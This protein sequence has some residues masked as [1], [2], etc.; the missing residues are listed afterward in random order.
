MKTCMRYLA[1]IFA[2]AMII[3]SLSSVSAAFPDVASDNKYGT[4]I[5]TMTNLGIIGGYEDGTFKPDGLVRRDEMAKIVFAAYTTY[6]DAGEGTITFPDV[7]KNSWAKGY[8]SWCAGKKIVGGYE[9]GT[10]RPEGNIT[11]DE[12]LKMVCAMLGYTNFDPEQWPIDV[13]VKGLNDL[14][15]GENLEGIA[16][17][18]AL[19]RAQIVQLVYNSLDKPTYQESD[20]EPVS[21]PLGAIGA[22]TLKPGS[23]LKDDVWGVEEIKAQIIGTEKYGFVDPEKE[24]RG[25]KTEEEDVILVRFEYE[26]GTIE[27]KKINLSDIGLDAYIGDSDGLIPL[28]INI[29]AKKNSDEYVSA[30]LIGTRK[31][32]ITG[33]YASTEGLSEAEKIYNG[34]DPYARFGVKVDGI[35]Y[36][37]EHFL[38]L[39]RLTYLEDIVI[40]TNPHVDGSGNIVNQFRLLYSWNTGHNRWNESTFSL[41][42]GFHKIMNA[43]DADSDGWY[44]YIIIEFKELFRVK[45]ITA[46]TVEFEYLHKNQNANWRPVPDYTHKATGEVF[47]GLD[48][49]FPIE[50]VEVVSALKEGMIVQGY[51]FGDTFTITADSTIYTGYIT[52]YDASGNKYTLDSGKTIG[53][54]YTSW[55]VWDSHSYAGTMFSNFN[56]SMQP[57]IGINGSTGDYNYAKFWTIEDKIIWAE[58]V[59][60][61][62]VSGSG[63]G[64]MKAILQ[65]VTEPTE[66]QVNEETK[67][68]EVFYPAYLLI[69]G[70][71]KLVNLNAKYAI[72]KFSAETVAQEGSPYR[73][74][75]VDD[76]GVNRIIY[77]NLLVTYEVDSDGYYTLHVSSESL[78]DPDTNEVIEMVIP[79]ADGNELSIDKKTGIVTIS[80][81]GRIVQSKIRIDEGSI[82]YYPY[83]KEL[84]GA[85]KYIDY[86]RGSEIPEEFDAAPVTS[87]IFLRFDDE[88]GLWVLSALLLGEKLEAAGEAGTD[89][90]KDARTHLYATLNTEAVV[91]GDKILASYAFKNLYT[92]EAI[93]GTKNSLEYSEA[94]KAEMNKI[95][96]WN[97]NGTDKNYV[98][99]TTT[100]CEA[101]KTNEV[102]TEMFD[103]MDIV[104]T[105]SFVDGIKIDDTVKVIAVT[106]K[107]TAE[108]KAIDVAELAEVYNTIKQYN[109]DHADDVGFTAVELKATI[110][111]YVNEFNKLS[112]AYILIDW[113][114]YDEELEALVF[115]GET[116]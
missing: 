103:D 76:N 54:D 46:K 38:N 13:R 104:F 48:L 115:A 72:D 56:K 107:E 84:T 51:Q 55:K 69:D 28:Y 97:V 15:L 94:T 37:N 18:A 7:P 90:T 83:T 102:I 31:N 26:D 21:G 81:N 10:F 112:V 1:V 77:P 4:A 42:Q 27:N 16:G 78:V 100:N 20:S 86:F 35:N 58:P 39:R 65:Y 45:K 50:N 57:L 92:L 79:A 32:D 25:T 34:K 88:S 87:D 114:E 3:C 111:T 95:Y 49:V 108:I 93:E 5:N 33:G 67:E 80:N 29:I 17:D 73:A 62:Q 44:D 36:Y 41:T 70:R 22:V 116:K 40:A 96:A 11:Y 105:T 23:T 71:Q 9:D 101:L 75:V 24:I 53:G 63:T 85:H 61:E 14:K 6:T 60:A 66:P 52:K 43:I 106:D 91:E 47:N 30:T 64:H 113:V 109:E 8:I 59:S 68:Y 89:W 82:L 98:E 110:G 2:V 12:A 99:V 74:S 19:T